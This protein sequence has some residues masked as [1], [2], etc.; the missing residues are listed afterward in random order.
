MAPA[1]GKP[2]PG[3]ANIAAAHR[4]SADY[5]IDPTTTDIPHVGTPGDSADALRRLSSPVLQDLLDQIA[6]SDFG[7]VLADPAGRLTRREAAT[8][9]TLA[10]MDDRSLDV[11]FSLAEPDVGTNGVGTSLETRRPAMVV[12]QDHF[13]ECFKSFTCANAPIINPIS[14][15]VEGTVGVLSP[16][17]DTSPLLL[18]T[19]IQLSSQIGELLLEQA[20]P[21]E[22]FLL[23]HFL[24]RRRHSRTSIAAIGKDA[25]IATPLAQRHLAGTDHAELWSRLESRV[26]DGRIFE[27]EIERPAGAPL[28]LRCEPLVRGGEFEGAA[29]EIVSIPQEESTTKSSR[30]ATQLGQLVGVSEPWR[31]LVRE[32]LLAAQLRE[33]VL[34]VGERGTG[35]YAVAE[36]IASLAGG[37][38]VQVFDNAGPSIDGAEA[39]LIRVRRALQTA[40]IVIFRRVDRLPAEIASAVAALVAAHDEAWVLAT[41]ET[42]T[43]TE[44]GSAALLDQL[45]VMQ[46]EVPPLRSRRQDI[47]P[48]AIHFASRLGR[49]SLDEQ[50]LSA[51]YRQPWPGNVIELRQAVRS[52]HARARTQP[53]TVRHLPRQIQQ[54]PGRRPLHGLRQHEADAIVAAIDAT[55]TRA[56]AADLLG[57][58]RATLFRRMKAYGITTDR[59]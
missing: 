44:S 29:V 24:L 1:P 9:T 32:A 57:M 14:R 38:A 21:E 17:E 31:S 10:A 39:W 56:E 42:T 18:S 28:H 48:L 12:G 30:R 5:G 23:R 27:I 54:S 53:L 4:R 16:V 35:R 59:F 3:T 25:L 50:V 41:A 46:I 19:A 7:L 6:D 20:T 40:D 34:V 58:S 49:A 8:R 47:A 36:A 13:L 43:A 55:S 26:P 15:R 2:K 51:L 45:N 11:G 22:R 52:A 37:D 33:P